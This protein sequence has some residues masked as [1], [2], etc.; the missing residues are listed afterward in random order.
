MTSGQRWTVSD[1]PA[2][3]EDVPIVPLRAPIS[4]RGSEFI[5]RKVVF[6]AHLTGWSDRYFSVSHRYY[7]C[8]LWPAGTILS[9]PWMQYE[10][11]RDL[12][13]ASRLSA[14][15][16]SSKAGGRLEACA[17]PPF[18]VTR[19]TGCCVVRAA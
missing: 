17:R 15:P 19:G 12:A 3:C 10:S 16:T 13:D 8:Q 11:S 6:Y 7:R 2:E 18:A 9:D 1:L 14:R 5:N 4:T